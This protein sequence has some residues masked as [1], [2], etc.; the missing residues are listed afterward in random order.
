VDVG[1]TSARICLYLQAFVEGS[2]DHSCSLG[3]L[4][5]VIFSTRLCCLITKFV[6]A[7]C[8]MRP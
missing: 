8:E 6:L 7:F 3:L 4:G 5:Y 1:K 2:F